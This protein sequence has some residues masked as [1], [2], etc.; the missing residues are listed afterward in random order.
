GLITNLEEVLISGNKLQ[1]VMRKGGASGEAGL[2]LISGFTSGLAW[3]A[4][5]VS[6][7]LTSGVIKVH[8][9]VIGY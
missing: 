5:L 2:G 6:G 7:A 8:A 9:N 1:V 4:P 3:L